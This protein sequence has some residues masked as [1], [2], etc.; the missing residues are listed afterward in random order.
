MGAVKT[1]SMT[2]Y[3]KGDFFSLPEETQLETSGKPSAQPSEGFPSTQQRTPFATALP[4]I[5]GRYRTV[6][7]ATWATLSA[8]SGPSVKPSL[9]ALGM[10]RVP[11]ECFTD[12]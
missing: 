4:S 10:T 3:D 7:C 5:S 1:N 11:P 6:F 8:P 2:I 12:S 9:N